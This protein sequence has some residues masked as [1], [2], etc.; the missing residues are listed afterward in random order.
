MNNI[1]EFIER[2]NYEE[3]LSLEIIPL[4]EYT[5]YL[6]TLGFEV[7]NQDTNGWQVDFWMY[8]KDKFNNKFL[9][10]GSLFYGNFKISRIK[11]E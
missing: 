6:E 8:F 4:S 10:D 2:K 7:E 3:S 9:V 11:D 1:K 5:N